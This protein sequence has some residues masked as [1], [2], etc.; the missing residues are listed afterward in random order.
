MV[1]IERLAS[2]A[3]PDSRGIPTVEATVVLSDGS[4]GT[5]AVPSGT[6]T[7]KHEAVELRDGDPTVQAGRGVSRA[8]GHV[9]GEIQASLKGR[10]GDLPAVDQQLIRLDATPNKHRLGANA[11]LAVSLA[12]ARAAA[13]H[14]RL[15]LY[16]F[17]A[18][19]YG[20]PQ[21]TKLPTLLVNV[22]EG[23]TH[24]TVELSV[25]EFHVI[26]E[27]DHPR[28]QLRLARDVHAALGQLLTERQ[29]PVTPGAEGTYT[30]PLPS[31]QAVFELLLEAVERSRAKVLFG[32]DAAASEFYNDRDHRYH[33]SPESVA[34]DAEGL[35]RLYRSWVNHYPLRL[36]EDPLA[37]DDWAGWDQASA[38]LGS[39]VQ[40][41]GDDL[42]TTNPLRIQAALNRRLRVGVLLKP[43][44]IGTVSE[45]VSAGQLARQHLLP[46][47]MANRS[48]ETLDAFIADFAVALG[49][50]YLKAG[51]PTAPERAVKYERLIAIAEEIHAG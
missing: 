19:T 36:I 7:G 31:H 38:I 4:Q 14:Y 48:G 16:A 46:T 15:S 10:P 34:Y 26:P 1:T 8:V 39:P 44:Q 41:I 20:Q 42:L 6:S 23:G 43:N 3:I 11:I 51:G 17:L 45:T 2:R 13:Q 5:A 28:D 22:F 12:L 30:A 29:L 9:V 27:A 37:E 47:V 35:A 49:V 33:L 25:Q 21:T 18:Q 40:L 50:D 24:A 32:I